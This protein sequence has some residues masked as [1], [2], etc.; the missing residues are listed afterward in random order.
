[1]VLDPQSF[2]AIP[3]L[4]RTCI[5]PPRQR[6][7][8]YR[9]FDRK[10]ELSFY[11]SDR[12]LSSIRV[13]ECTAIVSPDGASPIICKYEF[14]GSSARSIAVFTVQM[15]ATSFSANHKAKLWPLSA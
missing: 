15:K 13:T 11:R 10:L 9:L 12:C 8:Q 14:L 5:P 7:S 2:A 3:C 1:M 6:L 4:A